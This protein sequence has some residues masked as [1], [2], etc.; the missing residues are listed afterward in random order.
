MNHSDCAAIDRAAGPLSP[1]G[2]ALAAVLRLEAQLVVARELLEFH[3]QPLRAAL[4]A[5]EGAGCGM[6][7]A[8]TRPRTKKRPSKPRA[9]VEGA[10]CRM[11]GAGKSR[12][13]LRV[14]ITAPPPAPCPLPTS[15]DTPAYLNGVHAIPDQLAAALEANDADGPRRLTRHELREI[16]HHLGRSKLAVRQAREFRD[17]K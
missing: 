1:Y 12:S 2:L 17:G 11:R 4:A 8:G 3:A 10:G 9:A 16:E 7:G 13:T 15:A 5:L 6:Q 14:D